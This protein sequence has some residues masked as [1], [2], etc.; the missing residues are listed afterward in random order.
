MVCINSLSEPFIF[1]KDPFHRG[2][3]HL[4]LVSYG[5]FIYEL[6]SPYMKYRESSLFIR[7]PR[8]IRYLNRQ[9]FLR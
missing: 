8:D 7:L 4:R 6:I 9:H 1:F 5:L 2:I 3:S